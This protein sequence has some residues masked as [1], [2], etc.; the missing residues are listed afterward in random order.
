[1]QSERPSNRLFG[2]GSRWLTCGEYIS[3]DETLKRLRALDVDCGFRGGK[4]I[5]RRRFRRDHRIVR[6]RGGDE[7]RRQLIDRCRWLP[8]LIQLAGAIAKLVRFGPHL[9]H[10]PQV[11][12][13]QRRAVLVADVPA[14]LDPTPAAAG[15]NDR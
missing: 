9:L 14:G 2:L 4:E 1:M 11:Q 5:P 15:Q 8:E 7:H 13:A 12:I 10:H 3:T 6:L